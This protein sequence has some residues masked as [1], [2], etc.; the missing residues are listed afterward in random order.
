MTREGA[1]SC[2]RIPS[3]LRADADIMRRSTPLELLLGAL[4]LA[5]A[6]PAGGEAQTEIGDFIFVDNPG[7]FGQAGRSHITTDA[8]GTTLPV[9]PS[10]FWRCS[11]RTLDDGLTL[12]TV[13]MALLL[14]EIETA[15]GRVTVQWRFEGDPP[16]EPARWPVADGIAAFAPEPD[17][18]AFTRRAR[19]ASEVLVRVKD[20][21]GTFDS[22]FGLAE[23]SRALDRLSCRGWLE[24]PET[25]EPHDDSEEGLPDPIRQLTDPPFTT[26]PELLNAGEVRRAMAREYPRQL[27][28]AGIGGTVRVYV[29]VDEDGAVQESRIDESSGVREL[30]DAALA[31]ADVMRFSPARKDGEPI[32]AWANFPVTFRV[33]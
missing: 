28:E 2:S 22:R 19:T 26:P 30:D 4:A 18:D 16:S 33:R 10:L 7:T 3:H 17:R 31:V 1:I 29:F 8:A 20:L 11:E 13:E 15:D 6:L 21:R 32:P 23:L 25:G 24:D 9:L 12:T 5:T 14:H 27:R